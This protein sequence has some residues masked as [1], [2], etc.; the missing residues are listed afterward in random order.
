MEY[1]GMAPQETRRLEG[2]GAGTG[3]K[4]AAIGPQ[5][6]GRKAIETAPTR[7]GELQQRRH[8][9][10]GGQHTEGGREG[11]SPTGRP[12]SAVGTVAMVGA[13]S[14]AGWGGDPG[15]G[16]SPTTGGPTDSTQ[17]DELKPALQGVAHPTDGGISEGRSDNTIDGT[18]GGRD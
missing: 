7:Q 8:R 18:E 3:G 9:R 12:C 6:R 11:G 4:A 2:V 17:T 5:R 1:S 15:G 13:G 14:R 16:P 10:R